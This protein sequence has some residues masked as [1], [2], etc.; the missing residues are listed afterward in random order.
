MQV[1][2]YPVVVVGA[3]AN[4]EDVEFPS[5]STNPRSRLTPERAH[6]QQL[7]VPPGV[8]VNLTSNIIRQSQTSNMQSS[9]VRQEI[10]Q[11]E[12]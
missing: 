3:G 12:Q 5:G 4:G 1:P 11:I 9:T 2:A 6:Q 7:D 8:P 10:A